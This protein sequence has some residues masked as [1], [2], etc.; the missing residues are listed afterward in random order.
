MW[1]MPHEKATR[2]DLPT[3]LSIPTV[4]PKSWWSTETIESG[5]LPSDQSK[6]G[7]NCSSTIGMN[8]HSST[9]LRPLVV[10]APTPHLLSQ[11]YLFSTTTI[12][13]PYMSN[14]P[15]TPN[16]PRTPA[17]FPTHLINVIALTSRNWWGNRSKVLPPGGRSMGWPK[18]YINCHTPS[19]CVQCVANRTYTVL[20]GS[21]DRSSSFPTFF[22]GLLSCSEN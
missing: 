4:T 2:S 19:A 20:F 5:S 10:V 16:L 6:P 3:T 18:F 11:G 13:V 8:P 22:A 9:S 7:K 21:Q 15:H 12:R 1:W 17:Y 14:L